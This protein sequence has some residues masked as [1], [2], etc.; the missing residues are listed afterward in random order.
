MA[1]V[2]EAIREDEPIEDEVNFKRGV[3]RSEPKHDPAAFQARWT[4]GETV[5]ERFPASVRDAEH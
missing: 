2:N 4:P 5:A 3:N 1:A